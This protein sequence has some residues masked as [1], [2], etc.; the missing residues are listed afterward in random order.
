MAAS[1]RTNLLRFLS[2]VVAVGLTV[3]A[4]TNRG[5][6]ESTRHW[7][8]VEGTVRSV[9]VI[10]RLVPKDEDIFMQTKET[11]PFPCE[12]S[13]ARL[14]SA[15]PNLVMR[16]DLEIT[17]VLQGS[18]TEAKLTVAPRE[19]LPAVGQKMTVYQ[20]PHNPM[21]I[22]D[23]EAVASEMNQSAR[24]MALG[25]LVAIAGLLGSALLWLLRRRKEAGTRPETVLRPSE[26]AAPPPPPAVRPN[27]YAGSYP[28][29]PEERLPGIGMPRRPN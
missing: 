8:S 28:R 3:W 13:A 18:N 23:G 25:S 7:V 16:A 20:N 1:D 12:Q 4:F 6:G 14:A 21:Q 22:A 29:R 11:R 27:P 9:A 17:L 26:P 24:L 19:N 5:P 10:C 15:G 2:S